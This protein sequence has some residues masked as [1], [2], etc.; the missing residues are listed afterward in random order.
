MP[1]FVQQFQEHIPALR[2][3]LFLALQA[4][5]KDFHYYPG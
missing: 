4:S 2:C 3:N 1:N 5:K